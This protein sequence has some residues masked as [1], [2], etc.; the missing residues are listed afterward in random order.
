[1][2]TAFFMGDDDDLCEHIRIDNGAMQRLMQGGREMVSKTFIIPY[3]PGFPILVPGQVISEE[4]LEFMLKLDV[5]EIHGYRPELGLAVF[6]EGALKAADDYGNE[7]FPSK[8]AIEG[9]MGD[10]AATPAAT[11]EVKTDTEVRPSSR[12]SGAKKPRKNKAN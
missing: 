7:S 3:P 2:R 8:E 11:G 9:E 1:M 4:I 10:A 12:Q 6:T 5:K